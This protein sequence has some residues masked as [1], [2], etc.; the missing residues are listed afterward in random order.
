MRS[1]PGADFFVGSEPTGS[2]ENGK[3]ET[4]ITDTVTRMNNVQLLTFQPNRK[5]DSYPIGVIGATNTAKTG[6]DEGCRLM[7]AVPWGT[8][9]GGIVNFCTA[10]RPQEWAK[11]DDS[12][13]EVDFSGKYCQLPARVP[14]SLAGSVIPLRPVMFLF[15]LDLANNPTHYSKTLF[16]G[17]TRPSSGVYYRIQ[18]FAMTRSSR[19]GRAEPDSGQES[20]RL[21]RGCAGNRQNSPLSWRGEGLNVVLIRRIMLIWLAGHPRVRSFFRLAGVNGPEMAARLAAN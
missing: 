15:S 10:L 19:R 11:V 14:P 16:F 12:P 1:R 8:L 3:A 4:S 6:V 18:T 20:S 17:L 21:V 7:F 2:L 5:V 9:R 13:A